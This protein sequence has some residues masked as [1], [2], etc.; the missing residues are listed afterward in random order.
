MVTLIEAIGYMAIAWGSHSALPL[1]DA[2]DR[3]NNRFAHR[4]DAGRSCFDRIGGEVGS[5]GSPEDFDLDPLCNYR[6]ETY[7]V[8]D[9]VTKWR[10]IRSD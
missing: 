6:L 8:E 3:Y 9:T 5:Y 7:E 2:V 10:L 4:V 1:A